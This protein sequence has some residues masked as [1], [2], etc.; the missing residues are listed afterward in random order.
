MTGGR[1]LNIKHQTRGPARSVWDRVEQAASSSAPRPP[2][3]PQTRATPKP[4]ANAFPSL[5]TSSSGAAGPSGSLPPHSSTAWSLHGAP[6][7]RA[8]LS[9]SSKIVLV[10]SEPR[11]AA[12]KGGS[13]TSKQHK[14]PPAQN[15]SAFPGLPSGP[16]PKTI[17]KDA[18]SG[19]PSLKLIKGE[20]PPPTSAWGSAGSSPATGVTQS[21][22]GMPAASNAPP[23][24]RGKK[25]GKGKQ[26]LFTIGSQRGALNY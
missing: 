12:S 19:N 17:P 18:L 5:G 23:E 2:P 22:A 14:P 25:K 3:P 7:P 8:P 21:S 11:A 10:P 13:S 24:A 16:Y 4:S 9:S 6:A 1:I 26:T 20:Q 15:E